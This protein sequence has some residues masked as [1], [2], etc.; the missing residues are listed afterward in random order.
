MPRPAPQSHTARVRQ[1]LPLSTSFAGT[2]CLYPSDTQLSRYRWS[3]PILTPCL[4]S[5]Y[6]L[7]LFFRLKP[8]NN[9]AGS[10]FS[11]SFLIKRCPGCSASLFPEVGHMLA[12]SRSTSVQFRHPSLVAR[13]SKAAFSTPDCLAATV[14]G[15]DPPQSPWPF[16]WRW[17][18]YH[19][20]QKLR[21][22]HYVVL[23]N[24]ASGPAIS[25]EFPSLAIRPG[26]TCPQDD[27]PAPTL[28]P[29]WN[30]PARSWCQLPSPAGS[31]FLAS[32]PPQ[33]RSRVGAPSWSH[34]TASFRQ[35]SECHRHSQPPPW[36]WL[37][38]PFSKTVPCELLCN[39]KRD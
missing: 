24:L 20:L 28:I 22:R 38:P 34:S 23:R 17:H 39:S 1:A 29:N 12:L 30:T 31:P 26:I 35:M 37:S 11:F 2:A 36:C 25:P 3:F 9:V 10:V 32:Q 6:Y 27:F 21:A 4:T 14:L 8:L 13:I 33:N 18:L 15:L 19:Q 5:C 16:W 7:P